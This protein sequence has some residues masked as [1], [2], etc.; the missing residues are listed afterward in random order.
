MKKAA[1][2]KDVCH[3]LPQV[4]PVSYLI[5]H[6]AEFAYECGSTCNAVKDL[7]GRD[8]ER[9]ELRMAEFD[10]D[11]LRALADEVY[12][13]HIRNPQQALPDVF[14]P[15]LQ[16]SRAQAICGQH[17]KGRIDIA[18]FVVEAR[19][20]DA[21]RQIAADIA[22]LLADLVPQILDLGRRCLIGEED[23]DEGD[24]RSRI[25]FDPVEIGKLLEFL[26]DLVGNLGLHLIG[27]GAWPGGAHHHGL[28]GEGGIFGASEI[29][30]RIDPGTRDEEDQEQNECSVCDRPFGQVETFHCALPV[31]TVLRR[32]GPW[33]PPR[34][35]GRPR[36]RPCHH[37]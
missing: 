30:I 19:A 28:D 37:R 3:K 34:A 10:E 13:V 20:D 33:R 26:L 6:Q 1:V 23:A 9:C 29:E 24:A 27:R 18:I 35:S 4:K 22:D 11:P 31:F 32:R 7:L 36:S 8:A 14:G 16:L 21:G 15:G 12:L 25:A 2:E 5:G 17:V